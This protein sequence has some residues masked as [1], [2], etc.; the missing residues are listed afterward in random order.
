MLPVSIKSGHGVL[1][2][3]TSSSPAVFAQHNHSVLFGRCIEASKSSTHRGTVA[4]V[5]G[6]LSLRACRK[7]RARPSRRRLVHC[8]AAV[9][10]AEDLATAVNIAP[11]RA[12]LW[13][14][15]V[16]TL[17]VR[18]QSNG[19]DVD[20]GR[21]GRAVDEAL[22]G[23]LSVLADKNGFIGSAGTSTMMPIQGSGLKAVLLVGIGPDDVATDWSLTGETAA[24]TLSAAPSIGLCCINGVNVESLVESLLVGLRQSGSVTLNI[25][26]LGAY[27]PGSAAAIERARDNAVARQSDQSAADAEEDGTSGRKRA[28]MKSLIKNMIS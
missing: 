17:F 24:K 27:P 28:Y 19:S 8:A 11:V 5:I 25:D 16:L 1:V 6:G 10:D 13:T 2:S 9:E 23:Q 12:D 26:L 15:G 20:L 22:D 3:E 4:S 7:A 18:E 21:V 14:G